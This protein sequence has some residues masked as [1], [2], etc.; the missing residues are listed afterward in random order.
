MEPIHEQD[1]L[2][3]ITAAHAAHIDGHD[4]LAAL[5]MAEAQARATLAAAEQQRIANLFALASIRHEVGSTAYPA[6]VDNHPDPDMPGEWIT[7]LRPDVAAAL[8]VV[9]R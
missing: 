7:R 6:L 8:K 5:Y 3:C 1:A 2:D 4:Q 9:G